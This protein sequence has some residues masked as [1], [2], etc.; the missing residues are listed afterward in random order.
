MPVCPGPLLGHNILSHFGATLS[1]IPTTF[2]D[3]RCLL[4]LVALQ[5]IPT[6]GYPVSTLPDPVDP[7]VWDISTLVTVPLHQPVLALP[8]DPSSVPFKTPAPHF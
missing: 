2:L 3:S 7:Q 8:K 5:I 6:S 1:L 4:P